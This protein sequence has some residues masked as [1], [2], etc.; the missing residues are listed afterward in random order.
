VKT[1]L[2]II[3]GVAV[4]IIGLGLVLE[5][6]MRNPLSAALRP[7]VNTVSVNINQTQL[8]KKYIYAEKD[9][10]IRVPGKE[11]RFFGLLEA[12]RLYLNTGRCSAGIDYS[13]QAFQVVERNEGSILIR[14]P[15][16]EI[17]P[18]TFIEAGQLWDGSG[19]V[20]ASTELSNRLARI[21]FDEL[22]AQ[23]PHSDLLDK[24]KSEALDQAELDM[25]RVGFQ[26]VRV[27]FLQPAE[28]RP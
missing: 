6:V 7:P 19:F 20:V 5:L 26:K 28:P 8:V 16:P 25:Y 1:V 27:E 10:A 11:P 17:F 12:E 4:G 18:C 21:A 15:P 24:A 3:L 2:G 14:I 9:F 13:R 22:Q 23:A